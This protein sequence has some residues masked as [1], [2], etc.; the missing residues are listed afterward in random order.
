MRNAECR[1]QNAEC[2][3]GR[4]WPATYLDDGH[5]AATATLPSPLHPLSAFAAA[6]SA[7]LLPC[8]VDGDA[9]PLGTPGGTPGARRGSGDL[10]SLSSPLMN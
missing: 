1:V 8:Y 2:H 3:H 5:P 9:A 6:H 10:L 7:R 4:G